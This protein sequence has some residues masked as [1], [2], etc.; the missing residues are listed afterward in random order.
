MQCF[1]LGCP[2]NFFIFFLTNI[3]V[4]LELW[5][6]GQSGEQWSAAQ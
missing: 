2:K 1:K 5:R 3:Q 4:G 6:V